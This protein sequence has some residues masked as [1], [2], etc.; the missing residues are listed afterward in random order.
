M[1]GKYSAEIQW[2]NYSMVYFKNIYESK[3]LLTQNTCKIAQST[4]NV[5]NYFLMPE[6]KH[7]IIDCT[8]SN[9]PGSFLIELLRPSNYSNVHPM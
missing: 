8:L 3:I 7:S 5:R 6:Y 2:V 9:T 1:L 4:I